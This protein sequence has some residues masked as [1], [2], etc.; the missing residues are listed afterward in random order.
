MSATWIGLIHP[1][2]ASVHRF[3]ILVVVSGACA[4]VDVGDGDKGTVRGTPSHS[5]P[6]AL[7]D[8]QVSDTAA[9]LTCDGSPGQWPGCRGNGCAVCAE[10][11]GNAPCY[12][13]NHPDCARNTTCNGQYFECNDACPQPTSADF[14]CGPCGDGECSGD[15]TCAT[16]PLDCRPCPCGNG[17]CTPGETCETCPVDCGPCVCNDGSCNGGETCETCEADCGRCCSGLCAD[18]TPCCNGCQ[19]GSICQ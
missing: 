19:D 6:S 11:V 3:F 12:F 10:L 15:E 7:P 16:C 9:A 1:G 4:M 5:S 13:R 18:G 14:N 8:V 2:G 17:F